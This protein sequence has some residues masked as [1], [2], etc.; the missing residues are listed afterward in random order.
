M[1][2]LRSAS[3][4]DV[5]VGPSYPP[6]Q[7]GV[8]L[9]SPKIEPAPVRSHFGQANNARR[10]VLHYDGSDGR[11]LA[12]PVATRSQKRAGCVPVVSGSTPRHGL[13]VSRYRGGTH[14]VGH[15][16]GGGL[17][18]TS[19]MQLSGR[20]LPP[21]L[22]PILAPSGAFRENEPHHQDVDS[23]PPAAGLRVGGLQFLVGQCL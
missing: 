16:N 17:H 9:V 22:P 21:F 5:T 20:K 23:R 2:F 6:G 11:S 19:M 13:M 1:G 15:C 14:F 8:T 18:P 10:L 7:V 4:F 12:L 3:S